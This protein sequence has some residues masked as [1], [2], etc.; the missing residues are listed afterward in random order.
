[1]PIF[2]AD[3]PPALLALS[4]GEIYHGRFF[5]AA[6]QASGETV[7][8]TSLTGYQEVVTDPSYQGQLVCM[9]CS[10][11]G[12]VGTNA[13]DGESD[14]P[15]IAGLIVRQNSR[16]TSSWRAHGTLGDLLAEH[17]IPGLTGIDTRMLTRR[18][19][20]G[21]AINGCIA[22]ASNAKQAL[23]AARSCPAMAGRG[24]GSGAGTDVRREWHE[25]GWQA[26]GDTYS[27]GGGKGPSVA[28]LDC[29][30]KKAI[31]R[32]L[33]DRGA[34]VAVLP[35]RSSAAELTA[36]GPDGVVLS[37][38]PGDPEPLADAVRTVRRLLD[39]GTPLLGVCLGH[40]VLALAAGARTVKM[41]FGHHGCNHPVL[42]H[43]T[44]RVLISSQNHCFAVAEQGLPEDARITHT[45]LFDGSVQGLA[46]RSRP[47][48]SFQGHPEGSPG[49]R[50]LGGVFDRFM[51]L[52]NRHACQPGH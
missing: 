18:L 1:M 32:E 50:E 24:L 8:N 14:R 29:G 22:P 41:K 45:S 16:T 38:G 26:D 48:L 28:V 31:M 36:A 2:D 34:Q 4:S 5:G 52:A 33:A 35:Y 42:E 49:P 21:G 51:E 27:E 12:N 40:Q 10:H 20:S 30:A 37:N 3:G 19:R 39:S 23:A 15:Q 47:A 17:G 44:G 13:N 6:A 46:Y 25:C 11:I 9:T 43:N 7:F